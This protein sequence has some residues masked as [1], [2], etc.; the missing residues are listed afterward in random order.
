MKFQS[1]NNKFLINLNQQYPN[2]KF[3]NDSFSLLRIKSV[4]KKAKKFHTDEKRHTDKKLMIRAPL[5]IRVKT[6]LI[7]ARPAYGIGNWILKFIFDLDFGSWLLR[8]SQRAKFSQ[9]FYC[10][11]P[12]S[13]T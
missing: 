12:A 3:P 11:F 6:C 8:F 7:P 2:F 5:F 4:Q 13:M 1:S 9:N 10:P